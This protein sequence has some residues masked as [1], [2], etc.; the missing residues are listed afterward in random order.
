[1]SYI[2]RQSVV[3]TTTSGGAA[4]GYI[5]ADQGFL[6]SLYYVPDGSVPLDTNAVITITEEDTTKPVV[7]IT[8]IGTVAAGF[9]PRTLLCDTAAA[10]ITGQYGPIAI[11]GRIKFVVA[12]G[13]DTKTGTFYAYM[14]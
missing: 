1:M 2:N 9:L 14:I 4:T 7:V 3:L 6:W 13:G 12:S 10:A 11:H 5:N 8:H